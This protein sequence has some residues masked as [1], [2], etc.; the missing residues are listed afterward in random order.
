MLSF[1]STAVMQCRLSN[2]SLA[3]RRAVS[4][5]ASFGIAI[6]LSSASADTSFLPSA[7][8]GFFQYLFLELDYPEQEVLRSG[9]AARYIDVH[10][11]SQRLG[12]L[13]YGICI[14]IK[15]SARDSTVA[16]RDDIFRLGHLGVEPLHA[17]AHLYADSAGY[18]HHVALPRGCAEYAGAEPIDI[19]TRRAGTYHLDS[20][21][22]EAESEGPEGRGLAPF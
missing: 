15:N 22:G 14:M 3:R 19:K 6:C 8:G 2:P 1:L 7:Q 16:H 11:N 12:P 10:G 13:Y 17:T 5:R 18:D 4:R 9:R 20:A 21:A